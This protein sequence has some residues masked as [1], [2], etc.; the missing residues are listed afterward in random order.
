MG[1]SSQRR[2]Y[3]AAA[4]FAISSILADRAGRSHLWSREL[5]G[6]ALLSAVNTSTSKDMRENLFGFTVGVWV[7]SY[8][9]QPTRGT[10]QHPSSFAGAVST[11]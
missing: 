7:G 8:D 2:I 1:T 3:S 5:S 10:Q 9:Y 4:A 6:N 11:P